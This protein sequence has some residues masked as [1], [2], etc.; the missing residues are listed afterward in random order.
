[1]NPV[2]NRVGGR[3][4]GLLTGINLIKCYFPTIY[5]LISSC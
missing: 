5:Y 4:F 2:H 1:M 3:V